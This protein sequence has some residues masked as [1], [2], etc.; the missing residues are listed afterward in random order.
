LPIADSQR[1]GAILLLSI[2]ILIFAIRLALNPTTIDDRKPTP[3]PQTN[4][5][6]DT[7][8]PNTAS[9]AELAA[10]PDLGEKRAEAIIDFRNRFQSRHPGKPAFGR[11]S[12]LEQIEG[13]G[14]GTAENIEPYLRFPGGSR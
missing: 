8:D 5:L 14:A 3:A 7:L 6:A 1:R 2:L 9:A 11:I 13:I 12:D 4:E 10:I